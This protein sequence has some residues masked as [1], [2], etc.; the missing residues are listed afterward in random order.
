M[1]ILLR[2][3]CEGDDPSFLEVD[4]RMMTAGTA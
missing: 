4:A 3:A 2:T 1:T